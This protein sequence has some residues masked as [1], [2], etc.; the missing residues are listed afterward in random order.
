VKRVI[1][2]GAGFA[3]LK[4]A[5]V[6]GQ[7]P[8]DVV[9]VDRSNHHLFQP[10]LYQV[11]SAALNPGD[12]AAPIRRILRGQRNTA[13]LLSEVTAVDVEHRRVVTT[14]GPLAYDFL[15]LACG[16]THSYFGHDD[17]AMH[18]P[19]LKD[20]DDAVE[21]R[22][23]VLFAF[24]EAEH[25][26]DEQR[27]RALLT[28]VVIGAG[29][30]G[31]EL[32]G[33]LAEIARYTLARDFRHIDPGS[34]RVLLLEGGPRVLPVY[35]EESSHS[36]RR[37]LEELGVEVREGALVTHLDETGVRIGEEVV[38]ARTVLWAA[39][40]AAS[41]LGRTL[42]VEVDRAGRVPVEADLSLRAHPE[43]FVVGDMCAFQQDGRSVPG[44]APAAMQAGEH[45]ARNIARRARGEAT[46]PFRYVDKGSLATIGRAAAVAEVGSLRLSGW[47]AWV[48]WLA[49]H[50]FFLIGFRNRLLVLFEWAWAYVTRQRGVRLITGAVAQRV[51][52]LTKF[53]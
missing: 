46:L 17:W 50:V 5:K 20:L 32:A 53:R 44:V 25:E 34:A 8:L 29:P 49:I 4:A 11:A 23:R 19:G 51:R 39:G 40:V 2:V 24:E 7:A 42:G 45:A 43:I 16:A 21:I 30:T 27:R 14:D 9:V 37:Q 41:P 13:V 15:L 48:A 52:A 28:F 31:V 33:A 26:E 47:V 6:L 18:A 36:A 12:I 35:G 1:I 22:N 10:L 38:A 3:G